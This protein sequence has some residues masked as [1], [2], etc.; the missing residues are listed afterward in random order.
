MLFRSAKGRLYTFAANSSV[1]RG[2][3]TAI[4]KVMHALT[5]L[6]APLLVF[7]S[8]EIWQHLPKQKNE[9]Q[10]KSVHLLDWP[11]PNPVFSAK[12]DELKAIIELIPEVAK[13]LEE[14]R[15][16]GVIGSSFDAKIKLLTNHEN[17]YKYLTSLQSELPEIFKVSQVEVEKAGEDQIVVLKAGGEKCSRCWNYVDSVGR[18]ALH[19]LICSRCIQA[20]GGK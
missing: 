8:D 19:P 6:A 2:A 11:R 9:A 14:K 3:Q 13:F 18:D 15:Q 12:E 20:I 16:A 5:R 4:Y 7:T 10:I 1:R 17:R